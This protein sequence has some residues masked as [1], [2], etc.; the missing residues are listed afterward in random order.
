MVPGKIIPAT[1]TPHRASNGAHGDVVGPLNSHC[2]LQ[3]VSV[4]ERARHLESTSEFSLSKCVFSYKTHDCRAESGT[5]RVLTG[6]LQRQVNVGLL[7]LLRATQLSTTPKL[8]SRDT[9][10]PEHQRRGTQ[11]ELFLRL[12][13]KTSQE[14]TGIGFLSLKNYSGTRILEASCDF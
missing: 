1:V 3:A 10:Q 13:G 9:E 11:T 4:L 8:H 7:P 12:G 5:W 6:N 14:R 2:I